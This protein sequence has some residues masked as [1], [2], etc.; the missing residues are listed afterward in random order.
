MPQQQPVTLRQT[1]PL[2]SLLWFAG[3]YLRIPILVAPPLAPH[4][5]ADL[6][7]SQALTG[8]LT[9]LPVLMLAVGA[10]PGSL[11][12]AR[13]G[14]RA[15]LALAIVVMAIGSSLR[16]VAPEVGTLLAA[17]AIMGLGIAIM[18]PALPALLN[19]WFQPAHLALGTAVYMNGMLM[20][21]F[22][23]AGI[24]LPVLMP[25]LGD[26]WRVTVAAWSL[27]AFLVAAALFLPRAPASR[28]VARPAWVPDWHNPLTWKLGLLLGASGS[29]FFGTNAYLASLL[30]AR[31]EAGA[32]DQTLFWFNLAQ[33]AASLVMLRT[34]RRWVG[35][36]SLIV[37]MLVTAI[38]S[39]ALF[40]LTRGPLSI[41]FAFV[42]SFTA[43]ILLI[44]VVALPPLLSHRDDTGRLAAGN[45]T[46]GY[47]LSFAVPMLGGVVADFSGAPVVA[48][49]VMVVY[50]ALM[51]PVALKLELRM[52]ASRNDA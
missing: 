9:T 2:L 45:F 46:I 23:G 41:A 15:T 10:M 26:S 37:L 34:S 42:M 49:I 33:V 6:A 16:S 44:L 27:P 51:V 8:A 48:L 3:L 11:G 12:I 38:V 1:L 22:I 52:P 4:I 21:E 30:D 47:T 14:P 39:L 36:R 7:L 43:G 17:S 40:L 18:Q 25:M 20:G 32:L 29:M 28:P 5:A 35:R 31:G 19:V 50:A 13:M 24:T